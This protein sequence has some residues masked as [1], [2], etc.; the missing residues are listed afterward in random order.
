MHPSSVLLDISIY[1]TFFTAPDKPNQ[2]GIHRAKMRILIKYWNSWKITK[3]HRDSMGNLS[4]SQ[5]VAIST[6][7]GNPSVI[8]KPADKGSATVIMSKKNYIAEAERQLSN[9]KHYAKLDTPVYP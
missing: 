3:K 2:P 9:Q 6:L 4:E 5:L 1:D 8:F 7:K